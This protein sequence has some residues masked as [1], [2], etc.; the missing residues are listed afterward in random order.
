M[1]HPPKE[2][3]DDLLDVEDAAEEIENSGDDIPM[4]SDAEDEEEEV[5]LQNDSIAYFDLPQ[6]SLFTIAQHPLHPSLVAVGGSAG[7]ERRP[8]RRMALR[9]IRRGITARPARQL[10]QQPC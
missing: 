8:R 4:D 7:P 1:S 6:D 9:H 5:V 3:D 2:M 10:R